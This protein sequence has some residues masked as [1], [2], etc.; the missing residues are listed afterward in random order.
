MKL[1]KADGTE[2]AS[3]PAT[4]VMEDLLKLARKDVPS[5]LILFD[6]VLWFVHV[7]ADV[8]RAW[9]GRMREFMHSLTQAVAKVPR[10]CLV[11]SLLASDVN[12][13]DDLGNGSGDGR[14]RNA[15]GGRIS[16]SGGFGQLTGGGSVV[17]AHIATVDSA[18]SIGLNGHIDG[19]LLDD[20]VAPLAVDANAVDVPGDETLT[21]A[22]ACL[23]ADGGGLRVC[24][25]VA[26]SHWA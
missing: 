8:D 4:G 16:I 20:G 17:Q 14:E 11:A 5:V 18:S 26:A 23:L 13:M 3:P 25:W 24:F 2:R 22:C 15:C 12:K 6:E 1:L 9:I 7:M 19:N 10:C 21:V